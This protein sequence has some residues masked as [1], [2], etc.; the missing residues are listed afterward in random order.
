MIPIEHNKIDEFARKHW[1]NIRAHLN[2]VKRYRFSFIDDWCQVHLGVEFK[3]VVLADVNELEKII[4]HCKVKAYPKAIQYIGKGLYTSFSNS[5]LNK[6]TYGAK[7]L[8]EQM[9]IRVCPYCNRS[10]IT[11]VYTT[12]RGV[13]RTSHFD[14]FFNKSKYPF[15]GVSFFNLVPSC[16]AC[17]MIKHTENLGISPYQ[18]GKKLDDLIKFSY[19]FSSYHQKESDIRIVISASGGMEENVEKLGLRDMYRVHNDIVYEIIKKNEAYNNTYIKEILDNFG[20]L[21]K[22]NQEINTHL[23]RMLFGNYIDKKDLNKRVLSKFYRDIVFQVLSKRQP[24]KKI[25]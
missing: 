8:I 11:N 5:D 16:P 19:Y 10:F 4:K 17:N 18:T 7:H 25:F 9:G 23:L 6:G 22:N 21:Y 12:H 13:K 2:N 14:H 3:K 15:L 24:V 20:G 1:E